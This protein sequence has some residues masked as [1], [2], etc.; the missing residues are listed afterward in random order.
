MA[1]KFKT[2]QIGDNIFELPLTGSNPSWGENLSEIIEALADSSQLI[3]GPNDVLL[4]SANILNNQTSPV[5][6]GN[7]AFNTANVLA[8]EVDY[9]VVR[10]FDIGSGVQSVTENGKLTAN[11]D[12][13]N[14][15]LSQI[16]TGQVGVEFLITPQGQVRYL[17]SDLAGH[18]NGTAR[19]RAKTIDEAV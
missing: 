12:G 4:S 10:T 2:I 14:W 9:F 19:F 6:L 17:S 13:A 16:S 7:L 5:N 8:V 3:Q 11:Y 18:I 15:K 1:D